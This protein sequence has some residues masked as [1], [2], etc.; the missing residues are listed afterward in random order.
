MNTV[1]INGSERL[2][3]DSLITL[4]EILNET[5]NELTSEN[6]KLKEALKKMEEKYAK[7]F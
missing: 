1:S 2:D 3:I 6:K 7:H 5:N 4:N